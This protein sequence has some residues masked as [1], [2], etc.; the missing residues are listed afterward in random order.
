MKEK[1]TEGVDKERGRKERG[2]ER[3]E[4]R[5]GERRREKGKG[6][7]EGEKEEDSCTYIQ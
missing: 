7:R 2:G 3:E 5:E 6:A 4:V 1:V